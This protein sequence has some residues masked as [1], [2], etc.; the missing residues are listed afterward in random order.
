MKISFKKISALCLILVFIPLHTNAQVESYYATSTDVNCGDYYH[1]NGVKT[2]IRPD[3][4]KSVSGSS[5]NFSGTIVN[6]NSYPVVD[7]K[8]YVKILRERKAVDSN[9][10]DVLDSFMVRDGINLNAGDSLPI[11]FQWDIPAYALG[12]NY[13]LASYFVTSNKFNLAGLTFTDDIVGGLATFVVKGQGTTGVYL[14]KD[15]VKINNEPYSFTAYPSVQNATDPVVVTVPIVNTTNKRQIF[16][17]DYDVYK[18]DTQ[19][20]ENKLDSK[21]TVMIVES[22][23]TVYLPIAIRDNNSSVYYT[24]ITLKYM[25]SKS[26]LG[27]RFV[28]DGVAMPRI[29]FPSIN[30]YPIVSGKTNKIFACFHNASNSNTPVDGKL[31]MEIL[32]DDNTPILSYEYNGTIFGDMKAVAQDFTPRGTYKDFKIHATLYYN[33]KIVDEVYVPYV[34]SQIDPKKCGGFS[35]ADVTSSSWLMLIVVIFGLLILIG[36]VLFVRNRYGRKSKRNLKILI[37]LL[38]FGYFIS[39]GSVA[40]AQYWDP[41]ASGSGSDSGYY[42]DSGSG[43]DSGG[44][45]IDQ[46]SGSGSAGCFTIDSIIP[47]NELA[48]NFSRPVML[49]DPLTK[50]GSTNKVGAWIYGNNLDQVNYGKISIYP[51]SIQHKSNQALYVTFDR[52]ATTVPLKLFFADKKLLPKCSASSE[53]SFVCLKPKVL[54]LNAGANNEGPTTGGTE[55]TVTGENFRYAKSFRLGG[56]TISQNNII[57]ITDT[58]LKFRSPAEPAGCKD[59]YVESTC[60][61]DGKPIDSMIAKAFCYVKDSKKDSSYDWFYQ[62]SPD[63]G[64]NFGNV[65]SVSNPY[66]YYWATTSLTEDIEGGSWAN[67]LHDTGASITYNSYAVYSDGTVANN[68]DNILVGTKIAFNFDP[69]S[70]STPSNSIY[71]NGTGYTQDTPYG[72]WV[73]DAAYNGTNVCTTANFI[74]SYTYEGKAINIYIPLAVNPPAK[75]LSFADLNLPLE[76]NLDPT[77]YPGYGAPPILSNDTDSWECDSEFQTI[78][79]PRASGVKRVEMYHGPTYG[80]YYYGWKYNRNMYDKACHTNNIPLNE[81]MV[82]AKVNQSPA[83]INDGGLS[84][85]DIS[86]GLCANSFSNNSGYVVGCFENYPYYNRDTNKCY[87]LNSFINS[88][89]ND[90]S[91]PVNSLNAEYYT[92]YKLKFREAVTDYD[93]NVLDDVS[94]DITP[95]DPTITG[96]DQVDVDVPATYEAVTSIGTGGPVANNRLMSMLSSVILGIKNLFA[97]PNP[98]PQVRYLFDWDFDGVADYTSNPT[99]YN[100]TVSAS[101]TWSIPG[102]YTFAVRAVDDISQNGSNWIMK[103]VVVNP[104]DLVV[105]DKPV[106]SGTYCNNVANISWSAVLNAENYLVFKNGIQVSDSSTVGYLDSNYSTSDQYYVYAYKNTAQGLVSSPQSNILTS[107]PKLCNTNSNLGIKSGLKFYAKPNWANVSDG[108]CSFYGSASTTIVDGSNNVYNGVSTGSCYIDNS[109]NSV[110]VNISNVDSLLKK[111]GIGKHTLYCNINYN[112]GV[113]AQGVPVVGHALATI[114]SKCNKLPNV[115]EK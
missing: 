104:S 84:P 97:A 107:L 72:N 94:L 26:I 1:F 65:T 74:N 8:L 27:V 102:T 73:E 45:P 23:K 41:Y 68:Y 3:I 42:Y 59:F 115:I 57:S 49:N 50:C 81:K 62:W 98:E 46:G 38:S 103:T 18:W 9:G 80:Y 16:K 55:I 13:K 12:G 71:W 54:T 83:P 63:R 47:N 64:Y 100:I 10:P 69:T 77:V 113:D 48:C 110:T 70:T 93:F 82:I 24:E 56:V 39:T 44:I 88:Y 108:K 78:C 60:W 101:Y 21:S 14:K 109:N 51:L 52:L 66:L 32:I 30:S 92:P 112:A 86:S 7:G 89:H 53:F 4:V 106:I 96:P 28:R 20:P 11:S 29:N 33:D 85:C 43:S 61:Q 58:T 35:I 2:D 95:A 22:G 6:T 75:V 67:A 111:M 37:L 36:I 87:D 99:P 31:K 76:Y 5:I 90:P 25:D 34:C 105:L 79:A 91:L 15:G 40:H 19:A 17:I 114:D